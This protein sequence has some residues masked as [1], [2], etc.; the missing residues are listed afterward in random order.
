M[1]RSSVAGVCL[2]PVLAT[3]PVGSVPPADPWSP[4]T[5]AGPAKGHSFGDSID[6]VTR[7]SLTYDSGPNVQT[8]SRK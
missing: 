3:T 2:A 8:L 1:S 6:N 4:R 7:S 5:G